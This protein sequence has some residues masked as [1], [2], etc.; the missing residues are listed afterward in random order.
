MKQNKA[1]CCRWL[2]ADKSRYCYQYTKKPFIKVLSD[3]K[4]WIY[5]SLLTNGI[6]PSPVW[7]C[8]EPALLL[9]GVVAGMNMALSSLANEVPLRVGVHRGFCP[10]RQEPG[11]IG[12]WV[13]SWWRQA[14]VCVPPT[15]N[16][17]YSWIPAHQGLA[18]WWEEGSQERGGRVFRVLTYFIKKICWWE[19]A[20]T[21]KRLVIWKHDSEDFLCKILD[22]VDRKIH[23]FAY[24]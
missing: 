12:R 6:K 20:Q 23:R 9:Q 22:S 5:Q 11:V 15:G 14:W 8:L 4:L 16:G 19:V 21:P 7:M 24:I 3:L 1:D 10:K 2:G 13:L 17:K 18:T